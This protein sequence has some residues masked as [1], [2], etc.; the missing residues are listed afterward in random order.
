MEGPTRRGLGGFLA[1]CAAVAAL[2]T[3]ALAEKVPGQPG[4]F[5][6]FGGTQATKADFRTAPATGGGQR[7]RVRL[8]AEDGKTPIVAFAVSGERTMQMT[9]IR[10]DFATFKHL[11]PSVD[12]STGTFHETL[13]GLASD[14]RYYLYADTIP[15]STNEQVYRFNVQPEHIPA[16]PPASTL[17]ASAKSVSAGPYTVALGDTTIAANLPAKL[18]IGVKSHGKMAW[19][20]QPIQGGPA[21]ATMI[22]T[23]TLDYIHLKPFQRG[24]SPQAA[25]SAAMGGNA[26]TSPYMTAELPAL[27]AGAYKLWVQIRGSDGNVYTAPFTIVAQ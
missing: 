27:P 25:K 10:D 24:T 6:L 15:A 11:N 12:A 5:A 13:T 17:Q 22:D 21:F 2:G 20:L 9:L 7:V 4:T 8:F 16:V 19:D 3:V 1:A 18:L 14:H 23:S 26:Q